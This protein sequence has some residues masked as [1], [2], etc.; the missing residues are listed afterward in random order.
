MESELHALQCVAQ[1]MASLG[2]VI[3]RVLF[4]F[5]EIG[6]SNIP[7]VLYSDSESALKLLKNLDVPRLL[8]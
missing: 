5:N 4:T 2:K 7:G 1:E 3:G 8:K 6:D